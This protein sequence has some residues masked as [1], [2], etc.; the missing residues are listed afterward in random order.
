[1]SR[2]FARGAPPPVGSLEYLAVGDHFYPDVHERKYGNK[3]P[4]PSSSGF[5]VYKIGFTDLDAA[6]NYADA[7]DRAVKQARQVHGDKILTAADEKRWDEHYAR[8]FA[9]YSR[10]KRLP[11]NPSMMFE[12]NKQDEGRLVNETKK[13]HDEFAKKGMSEVPVPYAGELLVLL[14]TMPKKL[15]AAEMRAKLLAGAKCG[16]R[17]LD[18]NTTWYSWVVSRDHLPLKKAVEDARNAADVFARSRI[19]HATYS[20]GDPVYDEFLRRLPPGHGPRRRRPAR[21]HARLHPSVG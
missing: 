17:M 14:R 18:R 5:Q 8:W 16:D 19:S 12:A 9:H 6:H 1:M 21:G 13:L 15:S 2:S 20:P 10:M 3:T 4:P 7:V 11:G